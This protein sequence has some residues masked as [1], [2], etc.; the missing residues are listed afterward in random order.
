VVDAFPEPGLDLAE[1]P[2]DFAG[3]APDL[4][5]RPPD[6]AAPVSDFAELPA[7]FFVDPLAVATLFLRATLQLAV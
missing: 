6:F 1:W 3:L 2:P 7:R 4:A 5:E